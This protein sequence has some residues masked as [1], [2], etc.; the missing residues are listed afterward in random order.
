MELV[1]LFV[2]KLSLAPAGNPE[3]DRATVPVNPLT[4]TIVIAAVAAEPAF[5]DIDCGEVRVNDGAPVMFQRKET[6][7]LPAPMLPAAVTVVA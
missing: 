7:G 6:E 4:G 5:S 2:A 1:A 3:S